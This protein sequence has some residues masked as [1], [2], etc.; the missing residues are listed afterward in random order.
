MRVIIPAL[1]AAV[2][3]SMPVSLGAWGMDVHRLI[4]KRAIEHLPAEIRPFY[5]QRIEF[6]SEHA[7][8]PDLWRVVGLKGVMGDE[9]PNHFLD[10]DAIDKRPFAGIPRDYA[11]YVA[12]VGAD[13]AAR[14]GRL[15]WRMEEIY[16]KLVEEFKRIAAG[17]GFAGDNVR[18]L[19][20]VLSHY[21]GDAHQP[22]HAV[23]NYDGQATNQRG[24]HSRFETALPMRNLSVIAWTPVAIAP[25]GDIK[26]FAFDALIHSEAMV[27]GI[28]AADRA[29][30]EGRELYDDAY[31]A[32]FFK[33]ARPAL[34]KRLNDSVNGVASVIVAAWTAAGKPAL[35]IDTPRPPARIIR[36]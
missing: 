23:V 8:D 18:Y 12:K 7:A 15:P 22:F 26:T 9:D 5:L 25:I 6:I 13:N 29:A 24:I 35:A 20:A 11:A 21:V 2:A 10:M 19:S 17:Q 31:F 14:W 27:G 16:N 33:G 30:T 1:F 3:C 28:L 34:E 4:T 32:A 36:R